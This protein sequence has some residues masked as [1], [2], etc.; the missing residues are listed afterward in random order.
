MH[1]NAP[2]TG[3]KLY[4]EPRKTTPG[5]SVVWV[6]VGGL[7][8]NMYL[9]P[10]YNPHVFGDVCTEEQWREFD[11]SVTALLTEH[12][13]PQ[14]LIQCTLLLPPLCIFF[15]PY[16]CYNWRT[17][18]K[19]LEGIIQE[20]CVGWRGLDGTPSVQDLAGSQAVFDSV[21]TV[22]YDEQGQKCIM[23]S[24]HQV[25][26]VWPMQGV[27]IAFSFPTED[28]WHRWPKTPQE[29]WK[30]EASSAAPAGV[31]PTT[32]VRGDAQYSV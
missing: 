3:G 12:A 9:V 18:R 8:K 26:P 17:F 25:T 15:A 22:G 1:H 4:L 21:D 23:T 28:L 6:C 29:G 10:P 31:L 2:K 20:K 14:M 30:D 27:S 16:A 11:N 13:T 19:K 5:K 24:R 32:M 7:L